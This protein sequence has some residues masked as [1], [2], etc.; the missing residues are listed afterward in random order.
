[1]R[2]ALKAIAL[3]IAFSETTTVSGL[4]I[5]SASPTLENN[6][7]RPTN[8]NRSMLLKTGFLGVVRRRTMTCWRRTTF[9]ASSALSIE[10]GQQAPAK[11]V[12]K[13]PTSEARIARFAV[14]R[15]PDKI[16]GRDRCLSDA[17]FACEE[18]I[19]RRCCQEFWDANHSGLFRGSQTI[20]HSSPFTHSS[21]SCH[22]LSGSPKPVSKSFCTM[23]ATLTRSPVSFSFRR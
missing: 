7:W 20:N 1:M 12:C 5:A 21:Q 19:P 9:S 11:A 6:R 13:G 10:T 23:R 15:Q 8:I 14:T 22:G 17:A 3:R 18:Q 16:C 2:R 4:M